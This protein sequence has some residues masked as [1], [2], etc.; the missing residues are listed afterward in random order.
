MSNGVNGASCLLYIGADYATKTA[1]IG[2]GDATLTHNGDGIE[3]N[4]KST[5]GYREFLDSTD[6]NNTTTKSLDIAL[7][8]TFMADDAQKAEIADVQAKVIKDYIFD[9]GTYYYVGKFLPKL[10]T[11]T[12][13]KDTAVTLDITYQS[14]GAFERKDVP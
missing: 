14:S 5:G 2:Q 13:T 11:E 1:L 9:F 3:I 7:Q 6:G 8:L 12:A 4:N 10:N